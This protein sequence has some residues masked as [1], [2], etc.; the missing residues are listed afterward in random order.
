[1]D[2]CIIFYWS[3]VEPADL[4]LI[5][6]GKSEILQCIDLMEPEWDNLMVFDAALYGADSNV[7]Q[8]HY[9]PSQLYNK[10]S[11]MPKTNLPKTLEQ[12]KSYMS[13]ELGFPNVYQYKR[14]DAYLKANSKS[15][16]APLQMYPVGRRLYWTYVH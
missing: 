15:A 1:M 4:R 12:Q 3:F 16:A 13:D 7:V 10:R 11:T 8:G 5:H 2:V 14:C 9:D 6:Y